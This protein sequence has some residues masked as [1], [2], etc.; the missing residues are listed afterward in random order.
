MRISMLSLVIML[1][2]SGWSQSPQPAVTT[3]QTSQHFDGKWWSK[4]SADEHSGFINGAA[5]CLTW[6]AHEKGFNAT[7]EQLV[8]KITEFYKKHPESA[9][10][11]VVEVWKKIWDKAPPSAAAAQPGE[12]W[13]NAHWY[14]DGFWW[15][16]E[17]Q[18]Q[19]QGFVEGYLWC[20]RTHVPDSQETYSK[21]A[22][23]Y[24][25]KIDAF[26]RA[27]SNSKA[28]REKVASILR[29]YRDKKPSAT[30]K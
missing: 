3:T 21:S 1:A 30:P 29:R 2:V 7:P 5:D 19:K 6:T 14:L 18:E 15:L 11:S 13:K 12:T 24:V 26:A 17:T 25:E 10:L 4:T 27:H 22:S 8:G 9:D 16:D 20:M 28:G 23:F